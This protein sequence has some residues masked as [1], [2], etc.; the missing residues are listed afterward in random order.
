MNEPT[1]PLLDP[2]VGRDGTLH[3]KSV[4]TSE[5]FKIRGLVTVPSRYVIPVIFVPGIMG[6]NLRAKL[7]PSEREKNQV[8]APGEPAWRMPNGKI[9]G[10]TE[11]SVWK[12]RSPARRQL[13]L[14]GSTLE[15]DDGGEIEIPPCSIDPKE[16]RKRGW[17]EVHS[18]SYGDLL[19]E[20]QNHLDR[21][22]RPDALGKRHIRNH[23][24]RIMACDPKRWGWHK[25]DAV[26]EAELEKY[27]RFQYPVYAVGYNWLES[28]AKSADRLEKRIGEIIAYWADRKH[29][30]TQVILVTHSMGGLVA[31]ACAKRIPDKIAGVIHGVMPALGAPICYRRIAC[32]TE[33]SSP[34][35]GIT[36]NIV[37][38]KFA[39]I[40]GET[41]EATTAVMATAAGVLEM[42]PNHL[43]P[44][45]W[46]FAS[47]SR[48][49]NM[50]DGKRELVEHLRLPTGNPYD[51]YRDT[52]SWYR[53]INPTLADPAEKYKGKIVLLNEAIS[54]AINA[55]EHFHTTILDTYYHPHSY[56]YYGAD[57]EH[58]AY[59]KIH[60]VAHQ[61]G[62]Q[63][64]HPTTGE[65][66]SAKAVGHR[67]NGGR[68]VE[69]QK[70]VMLCFAP[71]TQDA[72]GDDT[73]PSQ[74]GA[75]PD[76]KVKQTFRTRGFGHKDSY[77]DV[78]MLMLTQHLIVKIVQGIK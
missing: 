44:G 11:A 35:N 62:H 55:A 33:S 6:S 49:S 10:V 64:V 61:S 48:P 14:D 36:A 67:P 50:G 54:T 13:H 76:G 65:M 52:D 63:T 39:E 7:S 34:N 24:Q 51:L 38:G 5:N 74:S 30:C 68:T 18:G 4:T 56:A 45:P 1:R 12:K 17:G 21:T 27:A 29:V 19:F 23:W 46:L 8:L 15:V 58:L 32:G 77:K 60:W 3:A 70:G 20:L 75:G 41:P 57:P 16:M 71:E 2:T 73:V 37:A 9:A 47:I 40:A 26:T 31:R 72:P 53:L 59:G 78:S 25:L 66:L 22:F 28:C 69:V 43:Y 42:L